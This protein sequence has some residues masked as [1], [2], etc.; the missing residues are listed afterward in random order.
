[1]FLAAVVIPFPHV[2]L[3]VAHGGCSVAG[4]CEDM[5]QDEARWLRLTSAFPFL[6]NYKNRD[7]PDIGGRHGHTDKEGKS[8]PHALWLW[9]P[10]YIFA[11]ITSAVVLFFKETS[12]KKIS[13]A[14]TALV[15][16][17][18]YRVSSMVQSQTFFQV[19]VPRTVRSDG[20]GAETVF[21]CSNEEKNRLC[22]AFPSCGGG[23]K[24]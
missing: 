15:V 9:V 18:R 12:N 20:M 16:K 10:I 23:R 24:G 17:C 13:K 4:V 5:A 22:V 19:N 3:S 2:C 21:F 1:M 11:T 8:I 7:G 6:W 14:K